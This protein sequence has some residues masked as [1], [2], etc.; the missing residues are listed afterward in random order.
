MLRA[1]RRVLVRAALPALLLA[2]AGCAAETVAPAASNKFPVPADG[3]AGKVF[4]LTHGWHTDIVLPADEITGPLK[5]FLDRFP[6]ARNVVFG[7]G[8]RNYMTS[9]EHDAGDWITGPFPGPGAVE[10]SALR[11]DPA[12]AYGAAH[13][14]EIHLPVG[15]AARISAFLWQSFTTNAAGEPVEAGHGGFPGS[16]VYDAARG[17]NLNHTCNTWSALALAAAGLPIQPAG[18]IFSSQ[19]DDAAGKLAVRT[20]RR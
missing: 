17:Y 19:L 4:L 12:T 18:I 14:M 3:S 1:M 7:Y 13:T 10:V 8:K 20:S 2:L 11:T 5:L 9:P 16:V 15:G 6:G